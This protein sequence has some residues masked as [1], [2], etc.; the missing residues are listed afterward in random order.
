MLDLERTSSI[1]RKGASSWRKP[2]NQKKLVAYP[3]WK[4]SFFPVSYI[5][6]EDVESFIKKEYADL[7]R[8]A[9]Y[10]L[11][12]MNVSIAIPEDIVHESIRKI[13]ETKPGKLTNKSYILKTISNLAVD[14]Q[15]REIRER[16]SSLAE[17]QENNSPDHPQSMAKMPDVPAPDNEVVGKALRRCIGRCLKKARASNTIRYLM[18]I[19]SDTFLFNGPTRN[20]AGKLD[21]N[22][23]SISSRKTWI[24]RYIFPCIRNCLIE[25]LGE[26]NR[27]E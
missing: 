16:M 20:L 9:A 6:L 10:K 22:P 13:M 5:P 2:A 3:M 25:S 11:H 19:D 4:K 23:R 24:K 7:N 14:H 12:Q 18:D 21:M 26:F 27:D 17:S 1:I 15:R 8:F